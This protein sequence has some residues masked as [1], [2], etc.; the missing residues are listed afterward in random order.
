M[1]LAFPEAPPLLLAADRE[2]EL[3]QLDA[4]ADEVAFELGRLPHELEVIVVG[5]EAHHAL[6]AGAVVPGAVE[7]HDLTARRRCST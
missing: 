3:D 4:A 2:P 5:A 7:Q 1:R 6:D